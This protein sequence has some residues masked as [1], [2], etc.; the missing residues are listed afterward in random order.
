MYLLDSSLNTLSKF[1]QAGKFV[2]RVEASKVGFPGPM[3]DPVVRPDGKVVI[4]CED[5]GGDPILDLATGQVVGKYVRQ[6]SDPRA[7]ERFDSNGDLYV[8]DQLSPAM[9]FD[10]VFDQAGSLTGEHQGSGSNVGKSAQWG[11]AFM[12]A[13]AFAPDG[14][15]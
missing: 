14:L 7:P 11:T 12:P 9:A 15:D 2:W 8:V 13:P 10:L 6:W 1:T 4:T 3:H 5:C